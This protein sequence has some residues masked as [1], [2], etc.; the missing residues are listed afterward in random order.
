MQMNIAHEK[1]QKLKNIVKGLANVRKLQKEAIR[2]KKAR[3]YIKTA[4]RIIRTGI[5]LAPLVV[6]LIQ[7]MIPEAEAE[8]FDS[9]DD[10]TDINDDLEMI[11]QFD[12]EM[13]E[14]VQFVFEQFDALENVLSDDFI[15][16]FVQDIDLT[17]L[18]IE[19][20]DAAESLVCDMSIQLTQLSVGC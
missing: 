1:E 4:G 17:D 6:G 7:P 12:P 5:W 2:K 9:T 8:D 11:G 20:I 19:E 14:S 3:K 10:G 15:D 13:I 16:S 18:S